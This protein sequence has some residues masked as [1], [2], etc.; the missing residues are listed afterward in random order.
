[1]LEDVIGD[2]VAAAD[3]E[4]WGAA[5]LDHCRAT[6]G[7]T[8]DAPAAAR[9]RVEPFVRD[10]RTDP[11][12]R[13]RLLSVCAEH[14]F[15]HGD[16]DAARELLARA[17]ALLG[18][19]ATAPDVPALLTAEVA[20]AGG[21]V[22]LGDVRLADAFERFEHSVASARDAGSSWVASWG[23]G[24][25]AFVRLVQ[26]RFAEARR[27]AD[28]ARTT[29]LHAASWSELSFT[30]ALQA[31]LADLDGDDER[32]VAHLQ[33][34]ERLLHRSGYR[35]TGLFLYPLVVQRALA[36][37]DVDG[38]RAA[39]GRWEAGPGRVPRIVSTLVELAGEGAPRGAATAVRPL[40]TDGGVGVGALLVAQV[41]VAIRGGDRVLAEQ[42]RDH[43]L[44]LE[45][46][47]VR[48]LPSARRPLEALRDELDRALG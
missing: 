37:G 29:Q 35:F 41:G 1:L 2:A 9:A 31:E 47:G 22:E 13:A 34:S 17:S 39:V 26:G 11:W 45:E 19:D 32:C 6:A 12:T 18:A 40:S 14:H 24:R 28:Q 20:F 8:T 38:A 48:Y 21:L 46:R 25:M 7:L 44:W 23:L 5:L 42:S 4:L 33:E 30:A 15:A 16:N 36:A 10:A 43:L 27:L 3:V